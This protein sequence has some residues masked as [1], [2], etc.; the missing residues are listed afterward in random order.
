MMSPSE[1]P[2]DSR[3][4]KIAKKYPDQT[5]KLHLTGMKRGIILQLAFHRAF[6]PEGTVRRRPR[7]PER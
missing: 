3:D 5:Q 2:M 7:C 4:Y 6:L 1:I